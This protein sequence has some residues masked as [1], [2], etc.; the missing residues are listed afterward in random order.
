MGAHD[1]GPSQKLRQARR[2]GAQCKRRPRKGQAR[3]LCRGSQRLGANQHVDGRPP[4]DAGGLKPVL[5]AYEIIAASKRA[6]EDALVARIPELEALGLRLAIVS[7]DMIEDT[8][9]PK[10]L[11]RAQPG[12]IA[13]QR[14]RSGAL[15]TVAEFAAA[16]VD[17]A[18]DE[19]RP[20]GQVAF[21]DP[22]D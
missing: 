14:A 10:L 2:P 1:E 13:A 19:N 11:E 16:I 5:A 22:V 8:I 15:P 4:V 20:N 12:L 17:A 18:D 6:G 7:G 21:I 9:T 3:L